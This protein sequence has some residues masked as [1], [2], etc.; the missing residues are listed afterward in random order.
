[1]VEARGHSTGK[2][3]E[4][5]AKEGIDGIDSRG[6]VI[7]HGS[8]KYSTSTDVTAYKIFIRCF[9]MKNTLRTTDKTTEK[10][11]TRANAFNIISYT[12]RSK[13]TSPT[14][15]TKLAKSTKPPNPTIPT[16]PRKSNKYTTGAPSIAFASCNAVARDAGR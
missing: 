6:D 4:H 1:M 12:K 13:D 16:N 14:K 15:P 2:R 5:T 7:A 10:P 9:I 11:N 3:I 8:A